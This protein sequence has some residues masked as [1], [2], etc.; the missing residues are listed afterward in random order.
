MRWVE[1]V[2]VVDDLVEDRPDSG[3]RPRF[4][5]LRVRLELAAHPGQLAGG[6]VADRD[7]VGA[8]DEQHDLAELHLLL[9]VVVARGAQ[10]DE[11]GLVVVLELRPLMGA[12]GVLE[13]Q[14]MEPE[15]LSDV[16]ELL[17]RR[18]VHSEPDEVPVADDA[19]LGHVE[20]QLALV[21]ANPVALMRAVDY[22]AG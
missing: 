4:E 13:R 12:V 15:A 14:L 20:R 22:H 6:P 18:L 7:H 17:D 19:L 10:D 1:S 5:Q 8:R 3:R 16:L 9:L 11:V 2:I 21:L